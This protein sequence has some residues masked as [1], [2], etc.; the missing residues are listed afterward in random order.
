LLK[1]V[2]CPVKAVN[3][4]AVRITISNGQ[5]SEIEIVPKRIHSLLITIIKINDLISI[6]S[7]II[8]L[9]AGVACTNQLSATLSLKHRKDVRLPAFLM[10]KPGRGCLR[11][12]HFPPKWGGGAVW[13]PGEGTLESEKKLM[14]SVRT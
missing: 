10:Q 6:N 2:S 8:R 9:Y 12:V 14:G 1:E 13:G 11:H 5:D 3:G 4:S 7:V